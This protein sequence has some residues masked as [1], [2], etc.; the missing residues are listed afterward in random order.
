MRDGET[1]LDTP[2]LYFTPSCDL[3]SLINAVILVQELESRYS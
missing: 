2:D 3:D 1:L